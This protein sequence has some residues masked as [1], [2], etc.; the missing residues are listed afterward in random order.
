[1]VYVAYKVTLIP[2]DSYG[3]YLGP[4]YGRTIQFD[5]AGNNAKIDPL[6]DNGDG[7]YS[8]TLSIPAGVDPTIT[9]SVLGKPLVTGTLSEI[10]SKFGT[11]AK[12][13]YLILIALALV[14]VIIIIVILRKKL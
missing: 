14:I 5:V 3:N 6:Q 4:D 13:P 2:K 1:M 10:E 9:V 12:F 8:T 7:S 11:D